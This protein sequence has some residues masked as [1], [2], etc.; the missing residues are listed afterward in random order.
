L[1]L[2][3]PGGEQWTTSGLFNFR[4]AY[5]LAPIPYKED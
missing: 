1:S 3:H 5:D 2:F 4:L